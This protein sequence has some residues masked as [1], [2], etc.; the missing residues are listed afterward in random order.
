MPD[1]AGAA[2]LGLGTGALTLGIV[3]GG[4]WGWADARVLG[5]FATAAVMIALFAW[6]ST[7]HRSPMLELDLIRIRSVAVG[8]LLMFLGAVGF[9]AYLLGNVLF[10]TFV[11]EYSVLEAGL[12]LTPGPFV[13][14][15]V[16]RPAE[17]LAL[18]VGER[19]VLAIG[20]LIWAGGLFY[21]AGVVGTGPEFLAEWLPGMV[22]L[23]V[24]A[25]VCFPVVGAAAVAEVPGG[26]FATATGLSSVSRQLGAVLGVALLVAIIGTPAPDDLAAAFDRG[27]F[28]AAGCFLALAAGALVLGRV[29][30]TEE[31]GRGER[32]SVIRP[33]PRA[34]HRPVGTGAGRTRSPSTPEEALERS[35]LFSGLGTEA[36]ARIAG[37]A[38]ERILRAGEWLFRRGDPPD[39]LYVLVAGRL[40]VVL[41]RGTDDE[42]LNVMQ[43]GAVIGELGLLSR[44]GRSASVRARRDSR[45]LELRQADFENLLDT[46]VAVR[47][48]LLATMAGQLQRSRALEPGPT[49]PTTLALVPLTDE[50]PLSEVAELL[51]TALREHGTLARVDHAVR[52]AAESAELLERCERESDRVLLV[53]RSVEP[54]DDWSAFCLRQAD[55]VLALAGGGQVPAMVIGDSRLEGCDLLFALEE[56]GTMSAWLDALEPRRR[57]V[58]RPGDLRAGVESSARRLA[59]HSNGI[60]FSGGGARAFAHIGILEELVAA[61]VII[62]RVA[63]VSMGSLIGGMFAAGMSPEEID[64][65]CYEEWVR[66]NPLHDYR[67]P[68]QSLIRGEQARAMFYRNLPGQIEELPRDFACIATD[69]RTGEEVV[70][71][72]GTLA[73]AVATS[74]ILPGIAPPEP[75]EGRLLVD[76]ALVNAL[77]LHLLGRAE[78]PII[79]ADA[80]AGSAAKDGD[81]AAREREPSQRQPGIGETLLRTALIGGVD[82]ARS[83][84]READLLIAPANV[85][86]GMLE[87]HQLDVA[88]EAG[89]RAAI[90]ALEAAPAGL[91]S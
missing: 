59:G 53:A 36:R 17:G 38:S 87:W 18:R 49:Q 3:K 14:A 74:M 12:A 2:L 8:N 75:L 50:A 23:G 11:W 35:P 33:R 58:L 83:A 88:K 82:A 72:R 20:A 42:L 43:P 39:S 89:R 13:A 80:V 46:E 51:S 16:A 27:W 28:F 57:Y 22:I 5:S 15:A 10:L 31:E 69:L 44:S 29:P 68:R 78:G 1:L 71:R 47:D 62:D 48:A 81:G 25:G 41:E 91:F 84:R 37:R 76:G 32:R 70:H 54:G 77:P 86:V 34:R 65:R 66:R 9:F 45:L 60:V 24:G 56:P 63:A 19:F 4:D 67:F 40:D 85:G 21:M 79:A 55:R 6:R 64:A 52:S 30:R 26:R 7:W 73:L 61:G 90:E